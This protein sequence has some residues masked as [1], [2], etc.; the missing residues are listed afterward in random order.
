MKK[1]P[2][3]RIIPPNTAE[4]E[5]LARWLAEWKIDQHLRDEDEIRASAETANAHEKGVEEAPPEAGQ[6]RLLFPDDVETSKHLR[7]VAILQDTGNGKFLVAP[8]SR[9]AEPATPGGLQMNRETFLLRV[10][11][12]WNAREIPLDQ[13]QR[14]WVV[15]QL[16]E[17]E[18]KDMLAVHAV[19]VSSAELPEHLA[20][21]IG[22][23]LAHPLDPRMDYIEEETGW[24]SRLAETESPTAQIRFPRR[25]TEEFRKAAE[26][27]AKY[28]TKKDEED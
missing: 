7:Y 8:F 25:N 20:E 24:M 11:C 26:E 22:P 2:N 19:I 13:I 9:F 28:R 15:D 1:L 16:P 21:R 12:L 4:S 17:S 18:I 23:P 14:S 3:I 27:R 10:L 6:I 5:R